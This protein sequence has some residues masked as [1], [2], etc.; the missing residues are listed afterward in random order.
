LSMFFKHNPSVS[1]GTGKETETT[2]DLNNYRHEIFGDV[3]PDSDDEFPQSLDGAMALMKKV[4]QLVRNSNHGKGKPLTYIMMPVSC[5]FSTEEPKM[6]KGLDE[7][8]TT[9]IV[10][11][12]EHITEARQKVQDQ[13]EKVNANSYCAT[14]GEMEN[15][16][17]TEDKLEEQE[18]AAKK[19]F[20]EHLREIRLG[21]DAER[22][23][24]FCEKHDQKAKDVLFEFSKIY[25]A[26]Q[27]RI[28]YRKRCEKF[29]AKYLAPP[30]EQRIASAC[31]D[32]DNVYVL[33]HGQADD[34]TRRRNESAFIEL[35]KACNKDSKTICYFTWSQQDSGDVRIKHFWNGKLVQEDVAKQSESNNVAKCVSA[36]RRSRSLLP[37]KVACPGP[38]DGD[39]SDEA[40]AWTCFHCNETLQFSPYYREL[41]CKCGHS[42][43][44]RFRFR[45]SRCSDFKPL[46]GDALQAAIDR[47]VPEGSEGNYLVKLCT[48]LVVCGLAVTHWS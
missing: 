39:C 8:W 1:Q 29:G 31:D 4:P 40:V 28:E 27:A 21:A 11:V 16:R 26:V 24:E 25:A 45:C 18:A 48:M 35:A 43:V 33:F 12:F 7:V 42:S 47:L 5:V 3:L 17:R 38:Y 14:Q 32:Y 2:N 46:R 44:D 37:F 10:N 41:Y 9:K 34:E 15:T 13:I 23:K 30:V 20:T 22:L 36:S 19:D 6:F